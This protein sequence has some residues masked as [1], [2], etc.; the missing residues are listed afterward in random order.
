MAIQLKL[1]IRPS[2]PSSFGYSAFWPN[3]RSAF[4]QQLPFSPRLAA[5]VQLSS[6]R[7]T[8]DIGRQDAEPATDSRP[9]RTVQAHSERIGRKARQKGPAEALSSPAQKPTERCGR[10]AYRKAQPKS[11][12]ANSSRCTIAEQQL[13]RRAEQQKPEQPEELNSS[14]QLKCYSS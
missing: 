1:A 12:N 4:V 14:I 10:K 13:G 11:C 2:G 5:A 8:P 7:R 6:R 3:R 9:Q